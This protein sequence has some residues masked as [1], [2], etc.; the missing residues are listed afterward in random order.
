MISQVCDKLI[1]A[2]NHVVVNMLVQQT[3]F[4]AG[5]LRDYLAK[6]ETLTSDPVIL[7][8]VTGVKIKFKGNILLQQSSR[9][10]SL[11]NAKERTIV[12]SEIDKLITKCDI[13]SSSP[14]RAGRFHIYDFL[15]SE[16]ADGTH[17]T[18][19]NLR[20]FNVFAEYHHFKMDTLEIKPGCYMASVG[21]KD[22]YYTVPIDP[23]PKTF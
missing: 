4:L 18:I 8:Y 21:L 14:E 9:R 15:A 2:R 16:K 6:W 1:L 23:S 22:A 3:S 13:V 10:P 5:R 17:R 11:F 20:Q 12:Q 7:Q 19:F